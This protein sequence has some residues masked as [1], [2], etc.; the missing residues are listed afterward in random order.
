M[1]CKK[2][3]VIYIKKKKKKKKKKGVQY[4]PIPSVWKKDN[5]NVRFGKYEYMSGLCNKF[6]GTAKS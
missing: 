3:H 4:S 6:K 1:W 2:L 5:E